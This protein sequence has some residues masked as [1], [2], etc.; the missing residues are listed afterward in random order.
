METEDLCIVSLE[1]KLMQRFAP[2][3]S[4]ILL[5]NC[6]KPILTCMKFE[7]EGLSNLQTLL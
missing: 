2:P 4:R 3:F 6:F 1:E 5:I 7:S